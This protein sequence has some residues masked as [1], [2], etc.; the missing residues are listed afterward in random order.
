MPKDPGRVQV[1]A[2][3][4]ELNTSPILDGEE[5]EDYSQEAE[6]GDGFC[7]FN[8]QVFALG[9][10]ICSGN[11]LLRCEGLGVWVRE[12]SCFPKA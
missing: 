2:P 11:E 10:Y 5:L 9:D 6:E 3:D 12:G 8:G 1:G 7:Y 4:P